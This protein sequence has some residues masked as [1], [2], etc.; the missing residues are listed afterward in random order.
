[1][2]V[3]TADKP[4]KKDQKSPEKESPTPEPQVGTGDKPKKKGDD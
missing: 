2:M 1:M 4:K 3:G